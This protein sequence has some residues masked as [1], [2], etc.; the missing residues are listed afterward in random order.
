MDE[1]IVSKQV[2]VDALNALSW[3]QDTEVERLAAV[4]N[5]LLRGILERALGMEDK[6]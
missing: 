4:V 5:I 6:T 2:L 3:E 1:D